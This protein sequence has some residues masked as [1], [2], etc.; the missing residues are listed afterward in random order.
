MRVLPV[1]QLVT[2]E[3]R[4]S[5]FSPAA[6]S[7]FQQKGYESIDSLAYM[8]FGFETGC[9]QHAYEYVCETS[10]LTIFAVVGKRHDL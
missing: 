2:F 1:R 9:T 7:G 10:Q 6:V 8:G 3:M 5:R 4:T